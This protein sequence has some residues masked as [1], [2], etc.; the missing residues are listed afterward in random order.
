MSQLRTE[1]GIRKLELA[2]DEIANISREAAVKIEIAREL[3]DLVASLNQLCPSNRGGARKPGLV[4]ASGLARLPIPI[5]GSF[6]EARAA[7]PRLPW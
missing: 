2:T 6:T 7:P 5:E 1:G 3:D 4:T